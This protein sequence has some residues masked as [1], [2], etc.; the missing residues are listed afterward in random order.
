VHH[1]KIRESG[2]FSFPMLTASEARR[3]DLFLYA[4]GSRRIFCAPLT[5]SGANRQDRFPYACGSRRIFCAP[6]TA[7]EARCRKTA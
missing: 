2:F 4:C 1:V 7:S 6:L 3:L 5:V